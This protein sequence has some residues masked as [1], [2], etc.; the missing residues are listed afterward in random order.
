RGVE[1]IDAEVI[2]GHV[3]VPISPD[4]S[5]EELLMQAE[6]AE[7]LRRTDLD[8]LQPDHDI[9]PTRLGRY[10]E[11]WQ[12]IEGHRQWLSSIWHREATVHEAVNDWYEYIYMP[13]IQVVRDREVLKEFPRLT[14]A[15]IYLWVMRTRFRLEQ[16]LGEDVGPVASAE[17]YADIMK[18]PLTLWDKIRALI[19]GSDTR[20][21]PD[22]VEET[23]R[24]RNRFRRWLK[25]RAR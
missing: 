24:R 15:D 21:S 25:P 1:F 18:Q 11:I 12:H 16:E 13:I 20:R 17:N 8:K 19:A 10:E 4:M 7:F 9:R 23:E 22:P 2:E 14:E 5:T 3:R 6:Y